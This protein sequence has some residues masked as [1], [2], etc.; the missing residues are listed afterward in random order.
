LPLDQLL[1]ARVIL[2][3]CAP[4]LT[5]GLLCATIIQASTVSRLRHFLATDVY[6]PVEVSD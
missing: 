3:A 6:E 4:V 5:W 2:V 1:H